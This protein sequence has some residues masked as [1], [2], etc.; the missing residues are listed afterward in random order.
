MLGLWILTFLQTM[1]TPSS[2]YTSKMNCDTPT[3]VY[4]HLTHQSMF[5]F[6]SIWQR[7]ALFPEKASLEISMRMLNSISEFELTGVTGA[8]QEDDDLILI[9]AVTVT[10]YNNKV[11]INSSFHFHGKLSLFPIN[12]K[13]A[14]RILHATDT[15][16]SKSDLATLRSLSALNPFQR[17][18]NK[19]TTLKCSNLQL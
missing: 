11:Q 8:A 13:Q 10:L 14:R 12:Y 6:C 3:V 17:D 2:Y 9:P 15:K 1:E 18:E 4:T 16:R 5:I 19:L 7:D